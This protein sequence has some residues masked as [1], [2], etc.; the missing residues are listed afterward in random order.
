MLQLFNFIRA[1]LS[2]YRP[3]PNPVY[4][5]GFADPSTSGFDPVGTSEPWFPKSLY[6]LQPL[7]SS[8]SLNPVATEAQMSVA[9]P[10]G[11]D[12][13]EWIN[14]QAKPT[15]REPVNYEFIEKKKD[16]K[17]KG[18]D[19]AGSRANTGKAK[20]ANKSKST[21]ATM[22]PEDAADAEARAQVNNATFF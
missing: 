20:K 6:L 13:D 17:G 5:N 12:L 7:F 22:S 15:I 8:Y 10:E 3:K 9:I 21:E 14:P 4:G 2:S 16:R 1:D 18:K 19:R 11:L